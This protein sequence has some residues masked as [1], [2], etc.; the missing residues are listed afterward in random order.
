MKWQ[1]T[2]LILC[3]VSCTS[4]LA[5]VGCYVA[6]VMI[7][8]FDGQTTIYR[9]DSK[10]ASLI[11]ISIHLGISI[12]FLISLSF[13][14]HMRIV[15]TPCSEY[16]KY[17]HDHGQWIGIGIDCP[18]ASETYTETT[19]PSLVARFNQLYSSPAISPVCSIFSGD[20]D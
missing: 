5:T 2:A 10:A 3:A 19:R 9:G 16:I 11:N 1:R 12:F 20:R 18:R 17:A 13:D 4:T 15:S 6:C 14:F 7:G 8:D